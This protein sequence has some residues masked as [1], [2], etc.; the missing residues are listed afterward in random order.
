M[1]VVYL[2]LDGVGIGPED[3]DTNPFVDAR[4][5]FL[6]RRLGGR[7][8]LGRARLAGPR[9]SAFPLD[10]TLG[11]AG[12]PQSGTGHA[13]LLTGINGPRR[14]GRHFGPWVPVRL[15]PDVAHGSFLRRALDDGRTAVFANAVPRRWAGASDRRITGHTLAA[16]ASG[17]LT[18]HE[19]SVARGEAIPS[20]LGHDRWIRHTGQ[21]G[22]PSL[23]PRDAGHRVGRLAEDA[24]LVA[25]AHYDTD[26]VGHEGSLP[27]ARSA[28]ERVDAFLAG[29]AESVPEDTVVVVVSDH[30][31]LET[32]GAGHTR[33]PALGIL[34]GPGARRRAAELRT[35]T[36][37]AP[38]V[39][40][41]LDGVPAPGPPPEDS[42][43]P[44]P[45][46]GDAIAP[47]LPTG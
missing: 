9:S 45:P 12:L 31:N 43:A 46:G 39:V 23:T 8:F 40:R 15:R 10:A 17:L 6:D 37:V 41:W 29:V 20:E 38:A 5:P 36:D 22:L 32:V 18:R 28:L 4:L 47:S 14:F 11:M 35:L 26:Q 16:R 3:P 27:E 34:L 44:E 7:P 25:F 33:N 13:S 19:E 1:R 42:E 30:G 21:V 24:D 2:F